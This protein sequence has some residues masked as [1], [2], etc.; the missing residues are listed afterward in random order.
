VVAGVGAGFLLNASSLEDEA[1]VEPDQEERDRLRAT[2]SDR[3]KIGAVLG[4]T[5][6]V[7]LAAGMVKLVIHPTRGRDAAAR[8]EVGFG[9]GSIVVFGRF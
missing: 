5:G 4:V 7:A 1:K 9:P 8:V 3:R 2:A 6:V